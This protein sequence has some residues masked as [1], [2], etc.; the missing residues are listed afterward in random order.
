[1]FHKTLNK[2]SKANAFCWLKMKY[3]PLS[4]SKHA[5]NEITGHRPTN[6]LIRHF[7]FKSLRNMIIILVKNVE[8]DKA[9]S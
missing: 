4:C 6:S 1:M 8:F 9:I 7:I 3:T 2:I 5:A